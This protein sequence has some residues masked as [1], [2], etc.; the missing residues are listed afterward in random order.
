MALRP[1]QVHALEP[2][3]EV[4]GVDATGLGSDVDQGLALVVLAGEEGA[5]LHLVEGLADGDELRLGL[6]EGVRVVHLL[7]ELEEHREVVDAP[8]QGLGLADLGLEVRKLARDLLRR[9]RV[10]PQGRRRG[11]LFEHGDVGPQLLEV[12]D[13]LDR[14]HGRGEGLQLFGYIDDCHASSVTARRRCY[15]SED[16][17]ESC[18]G[19]SASPE[20]AR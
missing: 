18:G 7:G 8:A 15:G 14:P 19:V 12:Q 3:G 13:G 16:C 17:L 2:L 9:L 20:A 10:V 11:L 4:G 5:D 6:G 1:A